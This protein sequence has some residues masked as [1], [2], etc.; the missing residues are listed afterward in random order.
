MKIKIKL[1]NPKHCNGCP[2]LF[3]GYTN[4]FTDCLYNGDYI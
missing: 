1:D 2:H 3:G 4:D